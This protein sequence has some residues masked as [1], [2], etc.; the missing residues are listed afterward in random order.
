MTGGSWSRS[1]G[2]S[3]PD[4]GELVR[5]RRAGQHDHAV[6]A[7]ARPRT[8]GPRRSGARRA[9]TPRPP[10]PRCGGARARRPR[11]SRGRRPA[12]RSA[13]ACRAG[14]AWPGR[15]RPWRA[16]N[17]P[18]G[19][20]S[21]SGDRAVGALRRPVR[22]RR[23]PRPGGR[24]QAAPA[25]PPAAATSL[26]G[27]LRRHAARGEQLVAPRPRPVAAHRE[28]GPERHHHLA[29]RPHLGG[30]LLGRPGLEEE[31]AQ[32]DRRLCRAHLLE[33]RELERS[34]HRHHA[35][36]V[37]R[38]PPMLERSRSDGLGQPLVGAR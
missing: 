33:H 31:R 30:H 24:R 2:G 1:T 36:V 6:A 10:A 34:A 14:G 26:L 17:T 38:Q 19:L 8:R 5:Q 11:R 20:V 18:S 35:A 29:E 7:L 3:T 9:R 16:Q 25:G 28:R 22:S 37:H 15:R 4:R 13:A 27:R 23:P 21:N 32:P 12:P